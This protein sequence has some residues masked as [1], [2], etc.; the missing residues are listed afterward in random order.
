MRNNVGDEGWVGGVPKQRG[1]L[2]IIIILIRIY[3]D[4]KLTTNKSRISRKGHNNTGP[5]PLLSSARAHART[6]SIHMQRTRTQ[7]RF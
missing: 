3:K 2:Q 4:P 1:C 6:H 5:T 7:H